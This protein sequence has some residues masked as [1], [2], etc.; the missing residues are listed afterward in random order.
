MHIGAAFDICDDRVRALRLAMDHQPARAFRNPEPHQEDDEAEGSARKKRKPP[1]ELGIDHLRVEQD[2]AQHRADRGADPEAAVDDEVGPAA[3]A[4]RH[5]LLDRRIDRR[6]FAADARARHKAAQREG[7]KIPG[8]RGRGGG[9]EVDRERH[10][11]ELL[12]AD[13]IGEPAEEQGTEHGAREISAAGDADVGIAEAQRRAVLQRARERTGQRHLQSVEYPGDAEGSDDKR[14]KPAPAEPVE[15]GGNIGFDGAGSRYGLA[16]PLLHFDRS[17][18]AVLNSH[19]GRRRS[20]FEDAATVPRAHAG[21]RK[22][23]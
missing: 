5:Q 20:H 10:E 8:Q 16:R 23:R 15:T 17:D 4:R 9:D 21:M 3:I 19:R 13:P 18:H 7:G 22:R 14:V 1:A 12:A 6:V 2:D 11:E